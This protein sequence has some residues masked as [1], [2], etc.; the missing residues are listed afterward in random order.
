MRK[1]SPRLWYKITIFWLVEDDFNVS[2]F[3]DAHEGKFVHELEDLESYTSTSASDAIDSDIEPS[4]TFD[5]YTSGYNKANIT[6]EYDW[7]YKGDL[8][9]ADEDFD[10]GVSKRTNFIV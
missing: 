5:R 4:A 6:N 1:L 2:F 9:D 10:R 3:L 8:D 7:R